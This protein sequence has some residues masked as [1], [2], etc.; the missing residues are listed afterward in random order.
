MATLGIIG[1]SGLGQALGAEGGEPVT[2]STPFGEHSGP[3][4]RTRWAHTNIVLLNRHGSGHTLGPS[5][6]NYRANIYAL[7]ALGCTHVIASGAVG[8]LREELAPRHLVVPDQIIDKTHRRR[9]TFFEQYL[10]AHVE[11]ASPFCPVLRKHLLDCGDAVDT[12]VHDGGTYVCMEGP[13]FSTRAESEMHRQ[14]GGDLI[15]MTLMPEAKL[16]REAEIA[17]AAVCLVSDYDCWRPAPG[18]LDR[19]ELLKEIIGHLSAATANAL[20]LI[21]TAVER[22]ERIAEKPSPAH[23]ALE[24]AIWSDR[25]SIPPAARDHYGPLVSKY[26]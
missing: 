22:F 10:A 11:L 20:A 3:I 13:A 16:A 1:G 15:G 4:V 24:L 2:V 23:S 12:S 9:G 6:V 17:Y 21:K 18:D 7:K 14:W 25:A 8:S 26:L 5:A 19:H